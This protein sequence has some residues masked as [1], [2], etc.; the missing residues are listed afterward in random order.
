MSAANIRGRTSLNEVVFE[1]HC[2]VVKLPLV[3]PN[4]AVNAGDSDDCTPLHYAV[5][6]GNREVMKLLLAVPNIAMNAVDKAGW[7]QVHDVAYYGHVDAVR[8]CDFFFCK[9]LEQP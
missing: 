9:V 7:T 8:L 5:Y 4:F 2:E 1:G 6:N 3:V